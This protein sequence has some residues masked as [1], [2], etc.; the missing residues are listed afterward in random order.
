MAASLAE[1]Q[2]IVTTYC[3]AGCASMYSTPGIVAGEAV[4]GDA[5]CASAPACAARL[6]SSMYTACEE[7][8]GKT[9][10]AGSTNAKASVS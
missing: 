9:K 8:I 2:R 1:V 10:V 3:Q 5:V 4:P 6:A 7:A